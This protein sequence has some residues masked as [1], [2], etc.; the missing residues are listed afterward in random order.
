[1]MSSYKFFHVLFSVTQSLFF[2][3]FS[4]SSDNITA[5]NKEST[6]EEEPSSV[7]EIT[8]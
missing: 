6:S 8:I 2:L 4:R 1:M 3:G 5:S 7:S